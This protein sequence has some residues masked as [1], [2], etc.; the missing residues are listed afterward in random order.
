MNGTF[1][2]P[3]EVLNYLPIFT[4]FLLGYSFYLK[5]NLRKK[6]LDYIDKTLTIFGFG[7]IHFVIIMVIII[8]ILI[9]SKVTITSDVGIFWTCTV[10]LI[11]SS[12]YI[13]YKE[14][15]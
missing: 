9:F 2:I 13:T 4:I 15:F 11:V 8:I 3:T 6:K 14:R 12:I 7:L 1:N 10:S 5:Y